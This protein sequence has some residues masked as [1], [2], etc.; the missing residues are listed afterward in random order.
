V[1]NLDEV[2]I[3]DWEDRGP[4][5]V[6]VPITAAL[7][8][9]HHQLSRS[10]KRISVVACISASGECLTPYVVT[11]R[12][13]AAGRRNLQAERMHIGRHL[14]L[15]HRDKPYANAELFE[16]YL[17]SV[18]LPHLMITRLMGDRREKDAVLLMDNCSPHITPIVIGL[19]DCPS[20]CRW[21]YFRTAPASHADLPSSR[22]DFVWR[23]GQTWSVLIVPRRRRLEYPT[24]QEGI[25]P[26]PD[27]DD[28]AQYLG[29]ISRHRDQ[30]FGC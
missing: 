11:S 29:S 25:S 26:L 16:D 14:L 4:K 18:F 23:S 9:I 27:H 2:G 21:D 3:S 22:F 1:F 20:A 12:D 5:K 19:L 10:V 8:S 13:S 15:K 24:H 28:R 17:R 7:H 6:V 30:V